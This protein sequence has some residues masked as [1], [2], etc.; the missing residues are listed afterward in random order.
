MGK[1]NLY[2]IEKATGIPWKRRKKR[3]RQTGKIR[4][5][6]LSVFIPLGLP[7]GCYPCSF[8]QN[9]KKKVQTEGHSNGRSR[10]GQLG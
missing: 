6:Q 7:E 4:S 8:F 2:D 5:A 3:K 1:R 10:S 9:E